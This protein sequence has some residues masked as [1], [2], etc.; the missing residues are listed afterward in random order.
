[1][2]VEEGMCAKCGIR[3]VQEDRKAMYPDF[4]RDCADRFKKVLEKQGL[5]N[6]LKRKKKVR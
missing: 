1:M 5:L 4:C 2:R 6:K 3:K